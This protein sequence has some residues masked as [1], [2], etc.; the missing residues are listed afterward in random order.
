MQENRSR[1]KI[2][3]LFIFYPISMLELQN[4]ALI[5][6]ATSGIGKACA[7]ILAKAHKNLILVGRRVDRLE[8]LKREF[9]SK[10]AIEVKIF[11]VDVQK[12]EEVEKM[13]AEL[14]DASIDILINNAGLARGKENF[15]T[16][17]WS[18]FEEMIQTNIVGFLKVAQLCVPFLKKTQGH[19]V[20]MSSTAGIEA[21][22][23][24]SVYCGTK[25]FVRQFSKAL[26]HDFM[27][28]GI[29]VT[30]IAPGNVETEFSN[31]RFHD[32][33]KAQS[34]Y[35]GYV[36]LVP[37]DVA[38]I[39]FFAVTRPKHVN[40]ESLV[41]YPTAQASPTRIAKDLA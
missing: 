9:E 11:A 14:K 27:G 32:K 28:N 24:G 1:A 6:G 26:R 25:A 10:Y 40:I 19:V 20:N 5:T 36:P 38:D 35:Q 15:E 22:E 13:F 30:D 3:W 8:E 4:F 2:G 16:Y 34:I 17:A 23:G 12:M 29:R 21:Y 37:E 33:D 7:E 18:D 39:V 41:V 31:V